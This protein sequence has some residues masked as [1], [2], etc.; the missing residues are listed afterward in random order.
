MAIHELGHYFGLCHVGGVE[1]IMFTP[2]GP[3]GESLGWWEVLKKSFTWWTLPK[4]LLTKGEPTFTLD[5]GMQ[6]WDYII[7]HFPAVCL[8]A[9]PTVIL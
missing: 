1:R 9:K 8:G 2:K 7:D 3:N 6:A 4:L 5:E